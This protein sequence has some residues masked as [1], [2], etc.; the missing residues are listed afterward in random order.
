MTFLNSPRAIGAFLVTAAL[1]AAPASAQDLNI[2]SKA[3]ALSCEEWL[4]GT[5]V[6]S[7][8]PGQIY[9]VE[10]W[11]TWCPPCRE[12]IPH[13]SELQKKYRDSKL[14]IIGVAGAE[15]SKDKDADLRTPLVKFIADKG[16]AMSYTVAYDNDRSMSKGWMEPA[17]QGGI[18]TAFVVDSTGTIAWIGH[19]MEMDEPLSKIVAGKWDI[20]A[21]AA[22]AK[23]KAD[24]AAKLKPIMTKANVA[25]QK[26]EWDSALASV[27]EGI[28]LGDEALKQLAWFK[29]NMLV[30][31]KDF[32]GA[33]GFIEKNLKGV[34][35]DEADLLNAVAWSTVDPAQDKRIEKK[36]FETALHCALRSSELTKG[37]P[38]EAA[39]LDTLAAVYFAKGDSAKAVEAQT[40]AV[41][42]MKDKPEVD[43]YTKKLETYKK[44]TTKL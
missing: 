42:L 16:D 18:P 37:K 43:E 4:K 27:D 24:F 33:Y 44:G 17:G 2:G 22:S 34:L 38:N 41:A 5:E 35:K 19:P 14:T 28:A 32:D 26:K 36:N 9:V 8:A 15:H 10:F 23:A 39:N 30:E 29:F 1:A 40:R 3:P 21:E 31:K 7:F 13:L 6:K 25:A 12:S 20:K 11:A